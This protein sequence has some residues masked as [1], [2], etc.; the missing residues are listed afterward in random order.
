MKNTNYI[1]NGVLGVAVIALFIMHFTCKKNCGGNNVSEVQ[2]DSTVVR[3][4]VAYIN[5]DSLLLNYGY[6][7]DLNET[8]LS[9]F[10]NS[11]ASLNQR[12]NKLQA[13]MLEFQRKYENNAF[14]SPER[15]QQEHTALLKRQQELQEQME[16]SQQD[17]GLEQMKM[18]QQMTD[19]VIAALNEF[20]KTKKYQIIFSNVGGNN[21]ILIAD[22]AYNITK[23]VTDYLNKR[24]VPVKK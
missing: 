20:N 3:L 10:E 16:R 7:K 14:L 5:T 22:D 11:R 1:I 12:G 6:A 9:K 4:P 19:T 18:N 8:L 13:D 21:N 17:L 23:E 24:Y 15:A 2:G